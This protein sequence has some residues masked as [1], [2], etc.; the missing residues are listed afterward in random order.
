MKEEP[1]QKPRKDNVDWLR[2]FL[3]G[4]CLARLI[5]NPGLLNQEGTIH[6]RLGPPTSI[7]TKASSHSQTSLLWAVS[8]LKHLQAML[9]WVNLVAE[10]N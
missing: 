1:K 9:G 10:A 3:S 5:W 6:H 2:R 8:Q 7:R 4:S